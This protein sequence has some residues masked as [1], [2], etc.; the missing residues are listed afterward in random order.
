MKNL[1]KTMLIVLCGMMMVTSFAACGGDDDNG[2]NNGGNN[3]GNNGDV[4]PSTGISIANL[5][6][7]WQAIAAK[8]VSRYDG[9]I[10]T[11]E[12]WGLDSL[13][14]PVLITI[15]PNSTF[16]SYSP[17]FHNY[18]QWHYI[19]GEPYPFSYT[20]E[21]RGPFGSSGEGSVLLIGN[22]LQLTDNYGSSYTVKVT[23]TSLTS[24]RMVCSVNDESIEGTITYGRDGD[25]AKRRDDGRHRDVGRRHER[26]LQQHGPAYPPSGNQRGPRRPPSPTLSESQALGAPAGKQQEQRRRDGLCQQ[27][28]QRRAA[29][30]H[31]GKAQ[32][33]VDEHVVQAEP[34]AV[35]DG[36]GYRSVHPS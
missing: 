36:V 8:G 9:P 6:G 27:R 11:K 26:A 28:P 34:Y 12:I 32:L 13:D 1:I 30:P 14:M 5:A 7:N 29:H 35:A 2:V 24:T 23:I 20:W 17:Q 31:A 16:V 25:G 33:S 3:G 19:N 15:N 18:Y 22:Q 4:N 21:K 10:D